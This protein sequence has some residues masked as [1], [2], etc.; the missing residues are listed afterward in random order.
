[1]GGGGGSNRTLVVQHIKKVKT[2]IFC[3]SSLRDCVN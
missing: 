3:V 2:L 1:M